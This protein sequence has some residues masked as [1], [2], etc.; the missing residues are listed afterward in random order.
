MRVLTDPLPPASTPSRT[1]EG[2]SQG[3]ASPTCLESTAHPSLRATRLLLAPLVIGLVLR[4]RMPRQSL[5]RT[6]CPKEQLPSDGGEEAGPPC[7]AL[8]N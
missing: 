6:M 3:L 2:S 7:G 1:V 8:A 4:K 5:G